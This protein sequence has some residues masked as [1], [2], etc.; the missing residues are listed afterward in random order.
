M[1]EFFASASPDD[2]FRALDTRGWDVEAACAVF[3]DSRSGEGFQGG[4]PGKF[5]KDAPPHDARLSL[6][7]DSV[8]EGLQGR[9][10]V[11]YPFRLRQSVDATRR[12]MPSSSFSM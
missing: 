12:E 3:Q 1:R 8:A 11:A 10:R 5:V 7:F 6:W 2:L 4:R 9:R